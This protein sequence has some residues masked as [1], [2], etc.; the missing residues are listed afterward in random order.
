MNEQP[1]ATR[2]HKT[3]LLDLEKETKKGN[4]SGSNQKFYGYVDKDTCSYCE[5]DVHHLSQLSFNEDK[6]L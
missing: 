3:T 5:D 6:S 4:G 2:L 1:G